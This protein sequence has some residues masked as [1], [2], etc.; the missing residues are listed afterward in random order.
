MGAAADTGILVSVTFLLFRQT[1]L[2][3]V[4][5]HL[6]YH[7]RHSRFLESNSNLGTGAGVPENSANGSVVVS[8]PC[9]ITPGCTVD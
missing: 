1:I 7:Q 2:N 5:V 3:M 4:Y 9:T 6:V 8:V